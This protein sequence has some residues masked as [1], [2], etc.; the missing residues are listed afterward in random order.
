MKLK[1]GDI[2]YVS[3]STTNLI[4]GKVIPPNYSFTIVRVAENTV[5]GREVIVPINSVS[6]FP[7]DKYLNHIVEN[8]R[9][10]I[11]DNTLSGEDPHFYW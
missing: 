3:D 8:I 9:R 2:V 1:E 6:L 11:F 7:S 4:G 5:I 10:E